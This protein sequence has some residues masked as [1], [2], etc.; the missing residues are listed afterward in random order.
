KLGRLPPAPSFTHRYARGRFQPQARGLLVGSPALA[1]PVSSGRSAEVVSGAGSG[2]VQGLDPCANPGDL[3][4]SVRRPRA[5]LAGLFLV[6]RN[7]SGLFAAHAVF[8]EQSH[9]PRSLR[10]RGLQPERLVAGTTT[11]DGLGRQLAQKP[12]L[13]RGLGAPRA[14]LVADG[15]RVVL[16]LRPGS[17]GFSQQRQAAQSPLSCLSFFSPTS[18][19]TA[20]TRRRQETRR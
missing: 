14:A 7:S 1:L 15:R 6:G 16:H 8:G 10:A 18:L 9:A 4:V 13:Q 11:I 5:R 12:P 2:D 3:A 19:L 17:S 20:K